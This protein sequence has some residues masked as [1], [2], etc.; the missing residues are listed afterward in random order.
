MNIIKIAICGKMCSGK[1]TL[2]E[3]INTTYGPFEK[4]AFGDKVKNITIDLFQI[5]KKD[6]KLLPK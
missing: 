4:H 1:S 5:E 2:S 3:Y 6:R